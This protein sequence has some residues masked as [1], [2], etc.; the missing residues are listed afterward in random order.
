MTGTSV[1]LASGDL[2]ANRYYMYFY[3]GTYFI[4][5]GSADNQYT[6][7]GSTNNFL[8]ISGSGFI[9]DSGISASSV[10]TGSGVTGSRTFYSA[11]A[12]GGATTYLNTIT[13]S[14]GLITGWT[15]A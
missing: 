1:N 9:Q 5:I 4:L 10:V 14:N 2:K 3:N 8:N 6:V 11:S 12:S 7:S 15:Q 13:I